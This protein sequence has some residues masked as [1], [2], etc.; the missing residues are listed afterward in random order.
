MN[1]G[2]DNPEIGDEIE[3]RSIV[4]VAEAFDVVVAGGGVTG[5]AAA[6]AAGRLGASVL[7]VE[8]KNFVGGNAAMGLQVLGTHTITGKRATAGIPGEFLRR[9]KQAGAAT[10]AILDARVCSFVAVEPAWVKVLAGEMLREAGVRVLLHSGITDVLTSPVDA[11]NA[12][13]V[14]GVVVNGTRGVR[15]RVVIDTT[16]DGAVAAM[17]GAPFELGADNSGKLQPATLIFRMGNVDVC[18]G[19]AAL[20][21]RG[22]QIVHDDFL[23][24][25]GVDKRDYA[26]WAAEFFN[27]NAFRREVQEAI[28]AGDLPADFP[29]QRVIWSN[30]LVPNEAMVLMAKVLGVDA[31]RTEDLSAAETQ[32]L[33]MVP[34]LVAFMRKYVPGFAAA[35]LIDV[36]PQVGV[37]ETRRILGEH[38]LTEDDVL[39]GHSFSDSIG[40]GGY[41][42]DV[43]P[44]Q[45]GDKRLDSMRYPLEPYE[46][47][48]RM[49]L[50]RDIGGL[51][52]AGRCSSATAQAFGAIRVIPSCMVQGEA[53]GTAAALC[54][55]V[56]MAPGELAI[57]SL[58]RTLRDQGV[59]LH[60]GEVDKQLS[61]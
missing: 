10:D 19:R 38:V 60:A 40:L 37:R 23:E 11:D 13:A 30:L 39:S 32:A 55:R 61:F 52:V 20:L 26:P 1:L 28:A 51:L 34:T 5:L 6:V 50:P 56:E 44:P 4:R 21:E 45:G 8:R 35:H 48:Y 7:L 53:A 17:A 27:A 59:Y 2:V 58:Q 9:L 54:A 25:I 16:G 43:H 3:K 42:L 24:S 36:A 47:P 29:Q 41:Y 49:L 22:H 31:S 57:E 15:S 12:T 46:M 33:A 18:G 14:N